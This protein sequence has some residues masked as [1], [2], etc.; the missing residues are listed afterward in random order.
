M[1]FS[2]IDIASSLPTWCITQITLGPWGFHSWGSPILGHQGIQSKMP[3][4]WGNAIMNVPMLPHRYGVILGMFLRCSCLSRSVQNLLIG[5]KMF[6]CSWPIG[7]HP[8]T[9]WD[10]EN[11]GI[12]KCPHPAWAPFLALQHVQGLFQRSIIHDWVQKVQT[13]HQGKF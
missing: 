9:T 1:N 4:S 2:P 6:G 13:W 10:S 8:H 3:P 11:P 5:N 7:E 12:P